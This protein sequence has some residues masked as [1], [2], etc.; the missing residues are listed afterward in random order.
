[1][2][3]EAYFATDLYQGTADYYDRY[4]LGYPAP[5]LD[6]LI[7]AT[8]PSGRGSL[9]DLAC[10][11]GQLAFPLGRH[12]AQTWAVDQEPDM[13]DT[14]RAKAAAAGLANVRPVV[15]SVETLD[16]QPGSFEL[17]VV[18]NAFH[19][20]QRDLAARRIRQWLIP[21]G[22]LALCW[23]YSPWAGA[24]DWQRTLAAILNRWQRELGAEDRTPAD[25]AEVRQRRPDV[26]VLSAA[27][28]EIVGRG[29]FD[30]EH[31]WSVADLAGYV[32]ST[33]FLSPAVLGARAAEFDADLAAGLRPHDDGGGVFTETVGF[34]YDLARKPA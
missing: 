3:D 17:A 25:P 2:G 11:T 22:H 28:F 31:R 29:S 13:I 8:G 24:E 4:R 23:S 14:V 30:V 12:F 19:R 34:A 32:R 1:M 27:G 20:F 21:G 9:L 5:L 15:S 26:E 6:H 18:G 33:S 16:A 10:G 7:A